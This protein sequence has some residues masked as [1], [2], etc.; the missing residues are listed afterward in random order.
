MIL[1]V[2]SQGFLRSRTAEVL[3]LLGG[4][5]ARSCGTDEDSQC[6]VNNALL[7]A[8]EIIFCMEKVHVDK[9]EVM[10]GAEG[11]RIESLGIPDEFSRYQPELIDQLLQVMHYRDERVEQA[12]LR[13]RTM[14]LSQEPSLYVPE[15][16]RQYASN[17]L[18]HGW[19]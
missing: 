2:C 6:P 1:F 9:V 3:C 7:M 13:G 15:E 10:M 19:P 16:P 12:M 5:D 14:L 8:A 18:A 4:L 11:K 17:R